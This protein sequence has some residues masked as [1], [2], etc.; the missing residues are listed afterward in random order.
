MRIV[1]RPAL[2]RATA[3]GVPA[4]PEPI[5]RA[6]TFSLF[7]GWVDVG[8]VLMVQVSVCKCWRGL[9]TVKRC[10]GQRSGEVVELILHG[11]RRIGLELSQTTQHADTA[12]GR[13]SHCF[14]IGRES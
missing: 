6:E 2:A 9:L 4:W 8:I 14:G 12:C 13:L 1:R 3:N 11:S 5:I 7:A 10:M